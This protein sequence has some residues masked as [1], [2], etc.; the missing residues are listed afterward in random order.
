MTG[1]RWYL[2]VVLS[3]FYL[4]MSDVDHFFMCLLAI[5]MS[6]LGKCLF[7]SLPHFSLGCLFSWCW[8][9]WAACINVFYRLI[10]CHSFDFFTLF[11]AFFFAF[12]KEKHIIHRPTPHPC[13]AFTVIL[14]PHSTSNIRDMGFLYFRQSSDTSWMSYNLI[15]FWCFLLETASDP[16]G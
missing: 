2:I 16:T 3:C 1:V 5:C 8:A 4:I 11:M 15:Y 13:F 9:V 12:V 14:L 6:S 10:L 7:R